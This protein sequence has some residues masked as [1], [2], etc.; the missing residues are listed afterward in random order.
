MEVVHPLLQCLLQQFGP[1]KLP[2]GSDAQGQKDCLPPGL[3]QP[4][5]GGN[6]EETLTDSKR[7]AVLQQQLGLNTEAAFEVLRKYLVA[8][9]AKDCSIMITMAPIEGAQTADAF[10]LTALQQ[11][12]FRGAVLF[13]P[14][15]Q[16]LYRY[17]VAF[18]DLDLKP[19]GKVE[20]HFRLDQAI[21]SVA[22]KA[23]LT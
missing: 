7:G 16:R 5:A 23:S 17:K 21:M 1:H 4:C 12:P 18:V 22:E 14:L 19:V 8:A 20:E 13:D 3:Q 2:E 9:T 15:L 11:D 10:E 6:T